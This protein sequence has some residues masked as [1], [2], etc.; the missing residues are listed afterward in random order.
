MAKTISTSRSLMAESL[1]KSRLVIFGDSQSLS[2]ATYGAVE[3]AQAQWVLENHLSRHIKQWAHVGDFGPHKGDIAA[4]TRACAD[5]GRL[6]GVVPGVVVDGNHDSDVNRDLANFNSLGSSTGYG[7]G[8]IIGSLSGTYEP[9]HAE[10]SYNLTEMAGR[11]VLT[12]GLE[13]CP[14]D[15]VVAWAQSI[16]KA[17]PG[18]MT[19]LVTHAFL[20]VDGTIYTNPPTAGQDYNPLSYN[21]TPA[22]GQNSGTDIVTKLITPYPQVKVVIC[23][24]APAAHAHNTIT[25]ADG[26]KCFA[27]VQDYQWLPG[28]ADPDPRGYTYEITFDWPSD[29]ISGRAFSPYLGIEWPETVDSALAT[30]NNVYFPDAGIAAFR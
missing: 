11:T 5:F 13:F 10:N 15:A 16:I 9:G 22:E 14:R 24:H 17:N 1:A 19:I 30:S 12:I 25:R 6:F 29:A 26:S 2:N 18:S 23:G 20:Y 7:L 8:D 4:W 21:V 3:T 27:F 28:V